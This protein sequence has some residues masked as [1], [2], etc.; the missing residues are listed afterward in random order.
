MSKLKGEIK[1][2]AG[3]LTGDREV[4]AKGRVERR[5]ADPSDP[6]QEVTEEQ[7]NEEEQL[8]RE[9]HG[10]IKRSPR[11]RGSKGE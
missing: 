1:E 8:V 9:R 10:D 11:R 7:V 6:V 5:A 4:E 3:A 2:I